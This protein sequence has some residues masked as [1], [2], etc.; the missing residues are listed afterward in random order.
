VGLGWVGDVTG[1]DVNQWQIWEAETV[2]C[3]AGKGQLPGCDINCIVMTWEK[4]QGMLSNA[5]AR[6]CRQQLPNEEG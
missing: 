6:Y 5:A 1:A 2:G 3:V 4:R